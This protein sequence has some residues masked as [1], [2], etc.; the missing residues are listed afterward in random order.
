MM[1]NMCLNFMNDTVVST[2]LLPT[3]RMTVCYQKIR[4]YGTD[5]K[6]Y[7]GMLPKDSSR[8][9]CRHIVRRYVTKGFVPT[10]LPTHRMTVCYQKIR[11]YGTADTSYDGMLPEDS[12]LRDY[13]HIV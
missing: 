11:P 12:S 1:R 3:Y 9:D 2:K 7:D 8:R 4:P 6:S 10:G 13:R 5:G